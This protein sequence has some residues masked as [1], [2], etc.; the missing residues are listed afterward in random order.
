MILGV[1]A[2]ASFGIAVVVLFFQGRVPGTL[3]GA[4]SM[5][6]LLGALFFVAWLRLR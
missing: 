1:L 6:L 3:L 5:D 2:K 4:G